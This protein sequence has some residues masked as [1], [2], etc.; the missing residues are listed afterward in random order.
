[1]ET[2]FVVLA[3][4]LVLALGI[5]DLTIRF[6]IIKLIV[7]ICRKTPLRSISGKPKDGAW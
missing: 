5:W 3:I 4:I 2:L 6:R 7:K 1:M